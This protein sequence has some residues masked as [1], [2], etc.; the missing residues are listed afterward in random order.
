MYKRSESNGIL[1]WKEEEGSQKLSKRRYV[2][3]N[4]DSTKGKRT[5]NKRT[6]KVYFNGYNCSNSQ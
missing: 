3:I 6:E 4:E 5:N 1:K 2:P